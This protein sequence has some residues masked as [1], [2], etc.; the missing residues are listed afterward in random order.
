MLVALCLLLGAGTLNDLDHTARDDPY[1][2]A[3]FIEAH[4]RPGDVILVAPDW[5]KDSSKA[6]RWYREIAS[7]IL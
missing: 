1:A 4:E 2:A 5:A 7:L 6:P 3:Q